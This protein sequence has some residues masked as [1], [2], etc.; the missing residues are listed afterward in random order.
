[1]A[2]TR[3]ENAVARSLAVRTRTSSNDWH[4]VYKARYGMKVA[5]DAVRDVLGDGC[6]VTQLLT[7]CTAVDPIL[8]SGL[9]PRYLDIS[10]RSA[11]IDP[12]IL[13]PR[14]DVRAVVLQHTYG[15]IDDEES[16]ALVERAHS[17]GAVVVED[18]A[19]CVGRM[20]RDADGEPL[21]DIS[22]HSFGIEKVLDTLYGGAVWVNPASPL[23]DVTARAAT[24]LAALPALS[25]H[26]AALARIN[27][28]ELR[29]FGHLPHD[30]SL[31]LRRSLPGLGLFD[32]AVAEAERRG[33]LPWEP[34]RPS[35]YICDKA[36][37]A[38]GS[39]DGNE[40]DRIA[41]VETYRERLR[42]VEGVEIPSAALS[43]A[44][45]P[46]VKFPILVA[47]TETSDRVIEAVCE[48]GY[49][50]SAWYRP[51]LTPGVLDEGAYR[52]PTDRSALS[53]C[54]DFIARVATLPTN[55]PPAAASRVVDAVLGVVSS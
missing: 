54:D 10:P 35:A 33:R 44:A 25:G 6:V 40:R 46:L 45:Q 51:E 12:A 9:Y 8:Q 15:I 49:F 34:A 38:L 43:G 17:V 53:R 52:I 22:I 18:C 24:L 20:A 42:G 11:S 27:R 55:I 47:D 14:D 1:M 29:V 39:L 2:R 26:L 48:A 4:C 31:S 37:E 5:F 28:F 13:V 21:A 36:L 16:R 19:H 30:L 50:T 41:V 7:C 23:T 3:Q 32:P